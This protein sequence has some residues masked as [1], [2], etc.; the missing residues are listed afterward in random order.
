MILL[1]ITSAL[2]LF[3][4]LKNVSGLDGWTIWQLLF[5]NSIWRLAHGLFLLF[6]QA[7]WTISNK[8]RMGTMDRFL[9]RPMNLLSQLFM[10]EF[11]ISGLGYIV[12]GFVVF[13]IAA[14]N[15]GD[16]W[17][18]YNII[19]SFVTILVGFFIEVAL[20]LMVGTLSFWVTETGGINAILLNFLTNFHQY[21]LSI[22][23]VALQY[24]LTFVI[25]IAF[26]NYYPSFL[27]LDVDSEITINSNLIY[28]GPVISILFVVLAILF[29][30]YGLKRYNSTGS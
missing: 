13:I 17:S 20:F 26:I 4:L 23:S 3:I 12:G 16:F 2:S 1:S 6:G 10:S 9:V 19:L 22:F 8:V 30:M 21:P 24:I 11:N 15:M 18:I 25:P 27:I 5:I 14:N 29:W 28:F 7:T